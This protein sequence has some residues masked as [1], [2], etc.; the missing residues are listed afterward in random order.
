MTDLSAQWISPWVPDTLPL[1]TMGTSLFT[2]VGAGS[3]LSQH[4]C[5][6]EGIN[7]QL[8][9]K[10]KVDNYQPENKTIYLV[11]NVMHFVML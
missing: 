8:N 1:K 5:F 11:F 9:S 6:H 2:S 3:G 4:Y 7:A 10:W